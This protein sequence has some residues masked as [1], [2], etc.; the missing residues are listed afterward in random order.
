MGLATTSV[1]ELEELYQILQEDKLFSYERRAKVVLKLRAMATT[2]D[3]SSIASVPLGKNLRRSSIQ[4]DLSKVKLRLRSMRSKVFL[5]SRV[6]SLKTFM[7][8]SEYTR[9]REYFLERECIPTLFRFK[10]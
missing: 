1:E 3:F 8:A 9:R 4:R 7:S 6:K 10:S 5:Q 2:S